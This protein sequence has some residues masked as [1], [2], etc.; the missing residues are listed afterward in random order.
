LIRNLEREET[1]RWLS[2]TLEV[3]MRERAGEEK[4]EEQ[5]KLENIIERH[6]SLIPR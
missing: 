2:D 3:L 4:K 1:K 5:K 6:K